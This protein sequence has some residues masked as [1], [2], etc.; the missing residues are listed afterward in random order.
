ML[1]GPDYSDPFIQARRELVLEENQSLKSESQ[2]LK[3]EIQSLKALLSERGISWVEQQPKTTIKTQKH[4]VNRA[5][6]AKKLLPHLP[7]EVQLR[8]L[9]FAMKSSTPIVDPFFKARN[10]HLTKIER[11]ERRQIPLRMYAPRYP[12]L[13]PDSREF[14]FFSM[15]KFGAIPRDSEANQSF[16]RDRH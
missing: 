14:P 6:P 3:A 13:F 5:F 8:I 1:D 15:S 9:G 11:V 10:E 12:C 2:I 7:M 16:P 4:V